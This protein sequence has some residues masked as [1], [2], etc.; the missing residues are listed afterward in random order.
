MKV[1]MTHHFRSSQGRSI[2]HS[3]TE[4]GNPV[5]QS[6]ILT[7]IFLTQES[8]RG[9]DTR[10]KNEERIRTRDPRLQL[11]ILSSCF[12]S[13]AFPNQINNLGTARCGKERAS[14]SRLTL[15]PCCHALAQKTMRCTPVQ[16]AIS[17]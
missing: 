4:L 2:P 1:F 6:L 17:T 9:K 5:T 10:E 8:E 13:W 15:G 3:L 12:V 11:F 16:I 7:Q 14:V